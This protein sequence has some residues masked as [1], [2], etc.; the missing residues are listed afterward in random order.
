ML[1]RYRSTG[2]N[3]DFDT[4]T[5]FFARW[6]TTFNDDPQQAPTPEILDM[7]IADGECFA[8]KNCYKS[9]NLA[10]PVRYMSLNQFKNILAKI[11]GLT[12]IAFGITKISSNPDF[13]AIM[14]H[15]AAQ[16]VVPNFTVA[17]HDT[18]TPEYAKKV[19]AVCGAVAVSCYDTVRALA[20]VRTFREAGMHQTNFHF[21]LAEETYERAIALLRDLGDRQDHG[22]RAVVFLKYKPKGSNA[23][24]MTP[25][26]DHT[27]YQHLIEIAKRMNLGIGFDSCSA[28]MAEKALEGQPEAIMIEPCESGLFSAYINVE[29]KFFPCSF[30]E[31]EGDWTEG[32]DMNSVDSFAEI[33]HHERVQKWRERLLAGCRKCPMFSLD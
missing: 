24:M 14:Q 21:V 31:G 8:C 16:G 32:I 13:L 20:M 1:K 5:G 3:Y 11:P 6:G 9:N 10:Q 22:V 27:K 29:G 7:E 4:K 12:Q 17:S 25:I 30:C 18:I 2:Y 19:A 26:K 33:W 15:C 23:G 28:P